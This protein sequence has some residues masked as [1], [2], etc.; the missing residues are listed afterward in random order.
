MTQVERLVRYLRS[1]P[2][3]TA[4]DIFRNCGI[5]KYTSRISDARKQ[6]YKIEC[7]REEGLNRYYLINAVAPESGVQLSAFG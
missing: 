3:A 1:H 2:G 7:L 5:P 6:G 4:D